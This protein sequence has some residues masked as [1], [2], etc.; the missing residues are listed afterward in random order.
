M[1]AID[2]AC[3]PW[4]YAPMATKFGMIMKVTPARI[5]TDE[6]APSETGEEIHAHARKEIVKQE[7][8]HL[9]K[10]EVLLEH[11]RDERGRIHVRRERQARIAR[12]PAE[13][14]RIPE[15]IRAL[16]KRP[17]PHRG[18]VHGSLGI[19]HEK[20]PVPENDVPHERAEHD[21]ENRGE[22]ERALPG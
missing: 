2:A 5:D 7:P 16:P 19:G 20:D 9:G 1:Y 15:G 10:T 8:R 21:D 3:E 4:P 12:H 6:R 14:I 18:E 22:R 17:L 11:I 13:E